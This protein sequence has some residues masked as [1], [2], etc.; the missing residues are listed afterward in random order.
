M[1]SVCEVICSFSCRILASR[2]RRKICR[3]N[4]FQPFK[5]KE[6]GLKEIIKPIHCKYP[7]HLPVELQPPVRWKNYLSKKSMKI[8]ICIRIRERWLK[9][10]YV[11]LT[12]ISGPNS[13]G[14]LMERHSKENQKVFYRL[15]KSMKYHN[16]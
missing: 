7:L 15:L 16:K 1:F 13:I 8:T 12:R 5:S 10:W 14:K 11:T 4:L 9:I 2:K 3:R 6:M